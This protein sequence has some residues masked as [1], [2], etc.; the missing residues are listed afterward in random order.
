MRWQKEGR[1][2]VML[3]RCLLLSGNWLLLSGNQEPSPSG[4]VTSQTFC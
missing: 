1:Q 2:R 3:I 4:L